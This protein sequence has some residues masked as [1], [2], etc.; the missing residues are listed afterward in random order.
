MVKGK[1]KN[2]HNRNQ[3]NMALSEPSS[4]TIASPGY[5]NTPVKQGSDLKSHL[6]MMIQDFK[7]DINTH[8]KKYGRTQVE[9]LKE[10]TQKSL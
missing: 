8:L 2:L 7:K 6:M 1:L 9:D 3:G 10:E 4:S 5:S